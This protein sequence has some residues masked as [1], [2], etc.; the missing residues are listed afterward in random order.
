MKNRYKLVILF[1]IFLISKASSQ[2]TL[3]VYSDYLSDNVYLLH[4][5][6]AGIGECGKIRLTG[7]GQWFDVKD[8]PNLQTLSFHTRLGEFSNNGFGAILFNDKNGY[9]SQQGIQLTYAYH[10]NMNRDDY[11]NQLSFGLSAS[12]V[13]NQVNQTRFL[14]DP[15]VSPIVKSD[16]YF[17]VD[18]GAAYHYGGYFTY[19]TIKN[20][21]LTGKNSLNGLYEPYNLR[22][23]FLNMGYFF[24]NRDGVQFEPSFLL[25]LK[26][27]TAEKYIDVN[28]KAYKTFGKTQVWLAAS[29]RKNFDGNSYFDAQY[30][31]PILGINH[32]R[33]MVSYTY[34]SQLDAV[35]LS[36]GG[37]HQITLGYNLFCRKRVPS[38]C[39]N[40][41]ASF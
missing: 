23:Y 10:I 4:P 36:N 31:T 25:Y 9:H 28:L 22:S 12:G 35:Q 15:T 37:F 38:A 19:F 11:F 14:N 32:K 29:Y 41:N 13:S 18:F 21:L 6:A 1:L 30:I 39:P 5:A 34:T 40:I 20:L 24:G 16:F 7:R 3:P 8:A 33:F 17:N 26:E 27:Q 2:E